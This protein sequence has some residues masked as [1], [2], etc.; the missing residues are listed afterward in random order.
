[1]EAGES[2]GPV[3]L[4]TEPGSRVLELSDAKA[5]NPL[6]LECIT[7]LKHYLNMYKT[8]DS[9]GTVMFASEDIHAF[10]RGL[11]ADD[12]VA[13]GEV[14]LRELSELCVEMHNYKKPLLSVMGGAMNGTAA[15]T[16]ANTKYRLAT[17][18]TR[19]RLDEVVT[20]Y[21]PTGG[22]AWHLVRGCD[23]GKA[24]ARYLAISQRQINGLDL[25]TL[26]LATHV[27]ETK[28]HESLCHALGHTFLPNMTESKYRQE[29]SVDIGAMDELLSSMHISSDID[30]FQ[31]DAWE[32]VLLV[33]PQ[34]ADAA[35]GGPGAEEEE[36]PMDLSTIAAQVQDVFAEGDVDTCLAKLAAI[37]KPW[38]QEA[39]SLAPQLDKKVLQAWFDVT[40]AATS[41]PIEGV[42]ALE[43]SNNHEL[44]KQATTN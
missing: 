15:G 23:E 26:G 27:T 39:A 36:D 1:M 16:F 31:S 19:M 2:E 32:Q 35:A 6:S 12:L 30:V 24:M 29:M 5:G 3:F 34:E 40:E 8:N 43:T 10:S 41:L 22:L 44:I 42:L 25:F 4:R 18:E 33:S 38:A 14:M 37:Q 21:V 17:T 11:D 20:G 28:P 7:E 13:N 9:V